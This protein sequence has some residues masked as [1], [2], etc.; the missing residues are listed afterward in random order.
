[1]DHIWG[2]AGAIV[3]SAGGFGALFL[4]AVKFSADQ[5]ADSLQ[6]KYDLKLNEELERYK[7]EIESKKYISKTKFDAEFSL[8][9][10]LSR[11]FFNMIKAINALVPTGLTT[12]PADEN[13]KEE[14]EKER[15]K[16]AIKKAVKA[17]DQLM[18]N[19]A[20]I[21][22]CYYKRYEEILGLCHQQIYEFEKRWNLSYTDL[23][24]RRLTSD[25]YQRTGE[26]NEKFKELNIEIRAHLEELEQLDVIV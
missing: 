16:Y 10:S 6:K 14:L 20:F 2:I 4:M 5:I 19:V 8:Y 24:D 25:A 12:V 17:Q 11:A 1:M 18:S 13:I 9:Q 15:Y 22:E 23:K 3:A 21:P 26:I 7:A